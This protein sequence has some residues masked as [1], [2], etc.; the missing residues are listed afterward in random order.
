[1]EA[2]FIDH[3]NPNR[4]IFEKWEE[5]LRAHFAPIPTIKNGGY[6]QYHFFEFKLG[7]ITM[8]HSP[9][10]KIEHT[11][12]Y[13]Q[14]GK[15]QGV[16]HS[17][18][19]LVDDCVKSLEKHLFISGKIF[20]DAT[21]EDI[22]VNSSGLGLVRHEEKKVPTPRL[23]SFWTKGFSIPPEYL[24]YYPPLPVLSAEEIDCESEAQD[25]LV[26]KK[27]RKASQPPD[28]MKVVQKHLTK[29]TPAVSVS[30]NSI[31]RFF[32]SPNSILS[33]TPANIPVIKVPNKP[34]AFHDLPVTTPSSPAIDPYE[35]DTNYD[36]S[37]MA[38]DVEDD[39]HRTIVDNTISALLR[40][41]SSNLLEESSAFI[42]NESAI[43]EEDSYLVNK[44]SLPI[45]G[46]DSI[47]IGDGLATDDKELGGPPPIPEGHVVFRL[48]G[49]TVTTGP[50]PSLY[51]GIMPTTSAT[52]ELL[53]RPGVGCCNFCGSSTR[54]CKLI[55]T[56]CNMSSCPG[57]HLTYSFPWRKIHVL[58]TAWGLVYR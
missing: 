56:G 15:G 39:H 53:P 4:M 38:A 27:R 45:H 48:K 24:P 47:L 41:S 23:L 26:K 32:K 30:S 20:T 40:G 31:A 18:E 10:S 50:A 16:N 2:E 58:S 44:N 52:S 34:M 57:K 3:E 43:V 6:T 46:E 8:R 55:Y 22:N 21:L 51:S 5:L 7:V 49:N 36:Y 19:M 17:H 33:N 54:H 12:V 14:R 37:G 35:Y 13:L 25:E 11:H 29:H 9:E 28:R 42:A 1:M